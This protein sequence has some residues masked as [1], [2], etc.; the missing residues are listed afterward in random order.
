M[1]VVVLFQSLQARQYG[2]IFF[3][4]MFLGAEGVVAKREEANGGRLVCVEC[5]WDYGPVCVVLLLEVRQG[6]GGG[7][8]NLRV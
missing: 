3:W 1:T 4:L 7:S 5:L 2:R 8:F 6:A